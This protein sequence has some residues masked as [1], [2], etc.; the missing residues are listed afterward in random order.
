MLR[1]SRSLFVDLLLYPLYQGK[2]TIVQGSVDSMFI[3]LGGTM[4]W[5]HVAI[6]VQGAC[7]ASLHKGESSNSDSDNNDSEPSTSDKTMTPKQLPP[8]QRQQ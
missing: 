6:A 4:A 1:A 7:H 3:L 8:Q 5:P 2:M